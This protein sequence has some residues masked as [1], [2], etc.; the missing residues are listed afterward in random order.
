MGK[1]KT[2]QAELAD[3]IEELPADTRRRIRELVASTLMH[4]ESTAF[5][6]QDTIRFEL[7]KQN[8]REI[9]DLCSQPVKRTRGKA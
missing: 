4:L 3:Y 5:R 1:V 8:L 2:K 7:C 9:V 6:L